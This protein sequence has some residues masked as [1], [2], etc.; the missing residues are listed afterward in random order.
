MQILSLDISSVST[1][2]AILFNDKVVKTGAIETNPKNKYGKRLYDFEMELTNIIVRER[3]SIVFVE[4]IFKGRNMTTFKTLSMFRGVAINVIYRLTSQEPVS[5]MASKARE[6]VG[7][8][9]D[10]KEAFN[11][12]IE[13]Y[14]FKNFKFEKDNDITDAVVLGL[15]GFLHIKDD[16]DIT[17]KKKRRRKKK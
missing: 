8:K 7:I 12:V 13:K 3:P 4:D 5:I 17:Y 14:G 1:G 11:F 15:A 16:I 9:N 2:Y 10:K 6:I